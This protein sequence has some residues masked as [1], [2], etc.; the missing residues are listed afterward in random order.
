MKRILIIR[1]SA[2]GD[3]VMAS[4]MIRVLRNSWPQATIAWL[5]DPSVKCLLDHH[6]ALDEVICWS[7]GYWRQLAR[8]GRLVR[9]GAEIRT[10]SKELRQ[11]RFDLALDAQGLLRSRLLAW[12]SAAATRIGFA[13][14][15]PGRHL[16]TRIVSRGPNSKEMSS[17]YRHLMLTLGLAPGPFAPEIALSPADSAA[18]RRIR[19]GQGFANGY[20]VI[21]PFTTRPQK[22]WI[23]ARWAETTA[24]LATQ[25]NLAVAL[26]GGPQDAAAARRIV[27]RSGVGITDLT[28]KTTLGQAAALVEQAALVIGVDTGLTHLGTAFKRPTIALFG[29]TCPYL[30]TVN[31]GTI[32]VYNRL[33]CSPCK[34]KPTCAGRYDCMKAIGTADVLQAVHGLLES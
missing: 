33:T 3:I 15:E 32:V 6:P 30:S 29:A 12:M 10:F 24:R 20:A 14:K 5:A 18:A 8:Q 2:I 26:L 16:M 4:P 23:E 11:R 25:F 13:S 22:H 34:R 9:L 1:P 27:G 7:K 17:E 21:C 19:A 28:G 31:R